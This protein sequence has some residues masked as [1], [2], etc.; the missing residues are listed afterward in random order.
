MGKI[1]ILGSGAAPG[2]PSI[3]CGWGACNPYNPKNRR[4]RTTI[5]LE[6]GKTQLLIDTSPDLHDE[7][8]DAQ[9]CRLDGVL[10][11]HCHADHLHGI[12]D[13]REL[14]RISRQSIDI[15]GNGQTCSFIRQ[16]F[17][18]LVSERS[19]PNNPIFRPSLIINELEMGEK[20]KI[21]DVEITPI[22][23]EG[24]AVETTGYIFN[25]GEV[26][27]IA[28]CKE[29]PEKSL[30]LIK[31]Q[32]KLLIMPLT[33]IIEQTFHMGLDKLLEY[34]KVIKPR[35]TIINHMAVECDYENVN[36][37]TPDHVMPAYDNMI[38][39]F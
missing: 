23:L 39:E 20:F 12:D 10:Y 29:I 30:S 34:V 38:I 13:L 1:I 31:K 19:H 14:N 26:V 33:T 36:K 24:H 4:R 35:E 17:S 5:Y 6:F 8:L 37:L 2:V 3:A 27:Y 22:A 21:N 7:L 25:D 16:R 28:D 15:Y 11:T 32:P 18:Y 9:I